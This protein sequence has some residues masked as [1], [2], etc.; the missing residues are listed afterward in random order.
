MSDVPFAP[1][2]LAVVFSEDDF[3]RESVVLALRER[4][5]VVPTSSPAR[6][7]V[8]LHDGTAGGPGNGD[9]VLFF[10]DLRL[11]EAQE[12]FQEVIGPARS[13]ICTVAIGRPG[14]APFA[15][16]EEARVYRCVD[17]RALTDA[18]AV[19]TVADAALDRVNLQQENLL[20]RAEL[21][22]ARAGSQDP[23]L[24][25]GAQTGLNP[26][27]DGATSLALRQIVR[28]TRL[29]EGNGAVFEDIVAGVAGALNAS[30]AGLYHHRREDQPFC[31][32]A[33]RQVLDLELEFGPEDPL[34]RWLDRFRQPVTRRAADAL[35]DGAARMLLRRALDLLGAESLVPLVV[36]GGLAGWVFAG[37]GFAGG[38]SDFH[39][40]QAVAEHASAALENHTVFQETTLQKTLVESVL[41]NLPAAIIAVEPDGDIRWANARAEALFP[42]LTD[43]N[44]VGRPTP[45][46]EDVSGR[47]AG[48]V[49]AALAGDSPGEAVTWEHNLT[50]RTYSARTYAPRAAG[51]R[52]G[53]DILG[54]F[55]VV[56]DITAELA[57]RLRQDVAARQAL[58]A[59]LAAGLAH[60]IRNPLVALKTFSQ[61]LPQR[62]GD[63]EFREEFGSLIEQDVGRLD[64]LLEQL[65]HFARTP[66]PGER[67]PV[68]IV[69]ILRA[70]ED[71]VKKL[72]AA[73]D[74]RVKI[75][76]AGRQL[77]VPGTPGALAQANA[78]QLPLVTVDPAGLVRA[79]TSL[80]INGVEAS[81]R[82]GAI[83]V[84]T[85]DVVRYGADRF[86][87]E[88]TA[89]GVGPPH[90]AEDPDRGVRVS[91][92][93]NGS[94]IAPDL[95]PRV[96]SPFCTTKAQGLGL[97]L[98]TAQG[99]VLEHGGR[100]E[101]DSGSRGLCVHIVLP[102][103]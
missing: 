75:V 89:G 99:I 95:L 94:G 5:Y 49:H 56:E 40:L 103:R 90:P 81:V 67:R 58:C 97:G 64:G 34:A 93:D 102:L 48:L 3:L 21:A 101:L 15:A 70:A 91:I 39:S 2:P 69:E 52:A 35:G 72:M 18:R 27:A 76:V 26:P 31:L 50:A 33:G 24:A 44:R 17:Y 83:P 74:P 65:D 8:L 68:H 43:R 29:Q 98:P 22:R 37:A 63:E 4:A 92:T 23:L 46:I 84:L 6:L 16:A 20:L 59:D 78:A 45:I 10:Y 53:G 38:P 82:K 1:L 55:A 41:G 80:F 12:V 7:R 13:R 88:R 47:L 100:L 30:R 42:V 51:G 28:P 60:E 54:V 87:T 14:S 62:H 32:R 73:A 19:A 66:K 61:L 11:Q 9:P 79:L 36:R 86:P 25:A 85:V 71:A 96:F 77:G 57:T